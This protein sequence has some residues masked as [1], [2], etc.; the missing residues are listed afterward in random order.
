MKRI[1]TFLLLLSVCISIKAAIVTGRVY[2]PEYNE[3]EPFAT[4]RVYGTKGDKPVTTVVSDVDGNFKFELKNNGEYRVEITAV[5]KEPAI[6][7]ITVEKGKDFN[8]GDIQ[9]KN[10]TRNLEEVTVVAQRP[11]VQ[12]STDEMTYNVSSDNDSRT[13]TLLEMLRKVPMVTVDGEDNI[14]V[15]GSSNFQVYVDGKPSLLFS[16]NPSMIFKSMPASA[17][18]KIEVVTNPGARYDAEGVGGVLNLVMNKAN[19]GDMTDVKAYN[20]SVGLRGSN[21]GFGGNIFANGQIGRFSA[22][23]NLMHNQ[24]LP[25]TTQMKT[26]R[27]EGDLTTESFAK[28]KPRLPFTMGSLNMEYAIDSLT[29]V[30]ASFSLNRFSNKTN[31]TINTSFT[32]QNELITNYLN[33]SGTK[34]SRQGINGSVNFS[35][36]FGAER[37]SRLQVTYQIA[38]ETQDNIS[39]NDFEV[40][41]PAESTMD[42]RA[43]DSRMKTTEQI[44]LADFN[45]KFGNNTVSLGL[46]GTFRDATA[47]N[48]YSVNDIYDPSGSLIYKNNSNIGAVYGEYSF[49]HTF[50]NIKAGLRYEHTWQ[51]IDYKLG[52]IDGYKNDY[53]NFVPS[54]SLG[55]NLGRTSNIGINYNLRISRPGISYL[56]PYVNRAD[57]TQISFGNPDLEV[58]KT[59]NTAIVYNLFIPKFTFNATLSNAY[60]G[61]GIEQYSFMSQGVLNTTYGNIV[62]RNNTTLSAFMN[63]MIGTKTR[64]FLNGS[65]SWLD[66]R[67]D[68]LNEKNHG[69]QGNAMMGVQQQLPYGIS[70]NV[71][72]IAST[73]NRTL[74]GWNTG[75]RMLAINVS[76]SFLEDRLGISLGFNTGLSKKGNMVMD[77]YVNTP[78]FTNQTKIRVPML[79]VNLGVT[80]KF[81]S[82]AKVKEVKSNRIDN[83]FI[84]AKSQMENVSNSE[85]TETIR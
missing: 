74:Q 81:G 72:M 10:D 9:L 12:M 23:L 75:F 58:E 77:T 15:N 48:S 59:H 56:N 70:A 53:G 65:M 3:G 17:V 47:D 36:D 46:K 69:L 54:G 33:H 27:K 13:Y 26:V 29:T 31:G 14:T 21:R 62:K 78:S 49:K 1:V 52:D 5:A 44:A 50:F 37:N 32:L 85:S 19:G 39:T 51:S 35:R 82:K 68:E 28:S 80:F 55:F 43:S 4:V 73:K 34:N 25:G 79:A 41:V 71:F 60:T 8:L 38:H 66:I 24:S 64:I 40:L 61:N 20:V 30:G 45:T 6:E 22:S 84:D 67:S 63:W 76:K 57:P 11:L 2:N 83:D 18:Q 7:K 42:S 16:G